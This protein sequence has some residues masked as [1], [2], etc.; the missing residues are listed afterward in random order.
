MVGHSTGGG[1]VARSIGRDVSKRVSKAVLIESVPPIMLK[2]ESNPGGLP[3]SVIDDSIGKSI[4]DRGDFG[5]RFH[6]CEL[7]RF[8]DSLTVA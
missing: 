7:S 3:K 8:V 4:P 5:D 1:E 6:L 2:T